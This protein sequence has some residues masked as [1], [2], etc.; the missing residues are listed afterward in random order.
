MLAKLNGACLCK[1][2]QYSIEG[3]I[4][5]TANCHCNTCKKST[6]AA[7]QTVAV[8]RKKCLRFIK[9]ADELQSYEISEK[10]SKHFCG[11]CGTPIYNTHKDFPGFAMIHI[12]SL[13]EPCRLTPST[14]FFCLRMLPWVNKIEQLENID[15]LRKG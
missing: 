8:I 6:G 7:F 14:N 10:A 3:E 2:L 4:V 12:G 13:D 9:D 11:Q 1:T 15:Q 5:T